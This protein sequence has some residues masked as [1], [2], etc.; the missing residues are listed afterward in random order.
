MLLR[1][2]IHCSSVVTIG[3]QE[4]AG[5]AQKTPKAILTY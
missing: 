2:N 3:T 1:C 5:T 4:T